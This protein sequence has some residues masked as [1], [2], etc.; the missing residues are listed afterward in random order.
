[1]ENPDE[2]SGPPSASKAIQPKKHEPIVLVA[3]LGCGWGKSTMAAAMAVY[4]VKKN[5]RQKVF[6]VTATDWLKWQLDMLY[7]I[8]HDQQVYK[9]WMFLSKDDDCGGVSVLT[10]DKLEMI[11]KKVLA[12][13][14]V[15][16]DE[17]HLL[18]PKPKQGLAKSLKK[19]WNADMVFFLSATFGEALGLDLIKRYLAKVTSY[20]KTIYVKPDGMGP[21]DKF[22]K[23]RLTTL[24]YNDLWRPGKNIRYPTGFW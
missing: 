3:Q 16:V 14:L 19:L 10:H 12:K 20:S 22:S 2:N 7:D 11:E 8:E 13:S 6:I 9:P 24:E 1:M 18:L 23:I 21:A 5:P 15:I 4:Y 17:G